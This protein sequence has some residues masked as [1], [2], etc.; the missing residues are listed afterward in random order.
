MA[1]MRFGISNIGRLSEVD[2]ELDGITVIAGDNGV[3]KSTVGRVIYA[4]LDRMDGWEEIAD[5]EVQKSIASF[6]R[7]V[8]P[9]IDQW[10]RDTF[11]YQ[12]S[13]TRRANLL[14][15]QFAADEE[16]AAAIEDYQMGNAGDTEDTPER[17]FSGQSKEA[18]GAREAKETENGVRYASEGAGHASEG[19][20]YASGEAKQSSLEEKLRAFCL[21]YIRLYER[22]DAGE[23]YERYS[24]AVDRWVSRVLPACAQIDMDVQQMQTRAITESFGRIFH[25]QFVRI[26]EDHARVTFKDQ[27]A[28]EWRASRSGGWRSCSHGALYDVP[29][30]HYIESP[31]ILDLLGSMEDGQSRYS[32]RRQRAH[33][34]CL[35]APGIFLN[36]PGPRPPADSDPEVPER[37]PEKLEGVLEHLTGIIHGRAVYRQEAGLEFVQ[38]G[39]KES[40]SESVPEPI[41]LQNVATGIKSIAL[42]EY[43]LRIG[44]IREGDILILDEPEQ[45]LHPAWQKAYAEALV[46]LSR[47]YDLHILVSSHSP[48]FIRAIEVYTDVYHCMDRLNAYHFRL[49][50]QGEVHARNVMYSEFGITQLYDSLGEPLDELNQILEKA[51]PEE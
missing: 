23:L 20:G 16:F 22:A 31:R 45:N 19:S 44:V 13:R 42:L 18:E 15:G 26:G 28:M 50:E 33:L 35:M 1:A 2:I 12:R 6:L 8:S 27:F 4:L 5:R 21:A 37:V 10:C 38:E 49:D 3:G 34:D 7:D 32:R 47:D 51:Y 25:G 46:M 43:A 36:P 39:M 14:I 40:I 41:P 9:E 48:Y 24:Q 29:G 17:R 11:G 30:V